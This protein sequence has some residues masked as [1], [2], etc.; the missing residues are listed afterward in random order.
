MT[1][2][3]TAFAQGTHAARPAASASN[4]GFYYYE[5]DT[6]NL[7]QSTGSA[8]QQ[9]ASTGGGGGSMTRLYTQTLGA[10]AATFD[11]GAAAIASGYSSIH[12]VALLKTTRAASWIDDL[13]MTFN[14]DTGANYDYGS[15]FSS[16]SASFNQTHGGSY[17]DVPVVGANGTTQL[18]FSTVTFTIPNYTSTALYKSGSGQSGAIDTGNTQQAQVTLQFGWRS[19]VALNQIT[20]ASANAANMKAG[21]S[22]QVYGIT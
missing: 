15:L 10:D 22:I 19:L 16:G 9:I 12:V 1:L 21:C 4:N 18:Y 5:T 20:F 13:K 8:W 11:T 2:L 3:T 7:F 14:G 6:Q 17:I